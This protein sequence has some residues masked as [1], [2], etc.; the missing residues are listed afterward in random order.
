M[1]ACIEAAATS[2]RHNRRLGR[3][4]LHLTDVAARRCL[5]R[6]HHDA[7][8]LDLI[9]NVGIYK[10]RGIAEPALA[11]IIQ[12]DLGANPGHPPRPGHHGTFSFD[13]LDGGCGVLSAAHLLDTFLRSGAA[14]LGLIVAGDASDAPGFPFAAAGGAVLLGSGERFTGFERFAF[15]SFPE[16]AA[17]FEARLRW[18]PDAG[19]LW[20]G[21]NVLEVHE[22]PA[23]AGHCVEHA[24]QV[25]GE[26]LADTGLAARDIDVLVASQY[27]RG[28]ASEVARA[29]D[30]P[31]SHV[32]QVSGELARAH[33][34]GPIAALEIAVAA[35]ALERARHMLF[36]TA[37][38]GITIGAALYRGAA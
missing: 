10:N 7:G 2:H 22:A 28:F 35:G 37:G 19:R 31:L 24:R 5:A 32:P 27:P 6:G 14:R 17:L 1:R 36:V 13:V 30:I 21:R 18:D 8:E 3:G 4:A 23:F 34:A 12:E 38:A 9:V 11:A 33:T 26:L 20:R 16:D 25:A 15:R 29:L